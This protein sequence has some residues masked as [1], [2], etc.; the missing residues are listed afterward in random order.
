VRI[1]PALYQDSLG[2]DPR[3]L[4]LLRI[5]AG[6]LF[7]GVRLIN[8]PYVTEFYSDAGQLPRSVLWTAGKESSG[9]LFSVFFWTGSEPLVWLLYGLS[10]ACAIALIVGWKTRWMTLACWAFAFS[11]YCRNPYINP[12]SDY[13]LQLCFLWGFFMPW[14]AFWSWDARG[15]SPPS[16]PYVS[17][18]TVAWRIQVVVMYMGASL[19]K[20]TSHWAQGTAVEVSLMSDTWGSPAGKWLA[21]QCLQH[22]GTLE[23]VNEA[24]IWGEF[25]IPPLMLLPFWRLQ[26]TVLLTLC[27][28]HLA[29]GTFLHIE[30]FS[31]VSIGLLVGF[32]PRQAW[33]GLSGL[34]KRLNRTFKSLGPPA[35][36]A[37]PG[38]VASAAVTWMLGLALWSNLDTVNLSPIRL[39]PRAQDI[40]G[41]LGLS[42]GWMMFAPPPHKGG[43]YVFRGQT[44]QGDWVNLLLGGQDP[45]LETPLD[46]SQTVATTRHYLFYNARLRSDPALS[47][48]H[49]ALAQHLQTRWERRHPDAQERLTRVEIYRISR[50]Y[51][52]G[53]GFT[54]PQKHLIYQ[55]ITQRP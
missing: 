51:E 16:T 20:T 13:Q 41:H 44:L 55:A 35:T 24:V 32:L 4:A 3:S 23:L 49:R 5:F 8:L 33:Q 36:L 42:Q 43:W 11:L 21:Q 27:G 39:T 54:A 12:A 7:L 14:G 19:A 37:K 48:N 6:F 18:A 46:T 52:A 9:R 15:A 22:P 17:L 30:A 47:S 34:Q 25:F 2:L 28:L 45:G 10:I 53:K 29:F 26:L 31:V 1:P 40:F 38:P 50:D